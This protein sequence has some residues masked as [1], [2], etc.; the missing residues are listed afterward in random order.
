MRMLST[1]LMSVSLLRLAEDY[2]DVS[3][4]EAA[5]ALFN[6]SAHI[7]KSSDRQFGD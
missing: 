3:C 6:L 5:V 1:M 2:E 4:K 7:A